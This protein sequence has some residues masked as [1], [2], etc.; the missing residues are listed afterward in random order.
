MT[1]CTEPVA[2]SFVVTV[3]PEYWGPFFDY[4]GFRPL[5]EVAVAEPVAHRVRDGLAPFPG[6]GLA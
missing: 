4:L 6:R 3:D 2:W 5:V 1:W